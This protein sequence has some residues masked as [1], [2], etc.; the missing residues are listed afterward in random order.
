MERIGLMVRIV[1]WGGLVLWCELSYGAEWSYWGGLVSCCGLSYGADWF[2]DAD[3][4][5]GRI[6]LMMRVVLRGGLVLLD[7][8]VLWGG[9]IIDVG[10]Y[11][12]GLVTGLIIEVILILRWPLFQVLLIL[13]LY[14]SQ[15]NSQ[16][17]PFSRTYT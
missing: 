10:Y 14:M 9:Q 5:M 12:V 8:F 3:C 13:D 17:I 15:V 7:G 6:G 16:I 2:Y 1:L 11:E 4:L